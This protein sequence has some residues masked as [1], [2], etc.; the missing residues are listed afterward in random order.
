VRVA[1][2][3]CGVADPPQWNSDNISR[4]YRQGIHDDP[5]DDLNAL[6]RQHNFKSST[7][8]ESARTALGPMTPALNEAGVFYGR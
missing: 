3:L 6:G 1:R 2:K 4:L 5:G 8:V 7:V